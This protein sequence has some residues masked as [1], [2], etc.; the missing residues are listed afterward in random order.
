MNKVIHP[1][2]YVWDLM[3]FPLYWNIP[4]AVNIWKCCPTIRTY[5]V[6]NKLG[7]MNL[8]MAR[9]EGKNSWWEYIFKKEQ[10][11]LLNMVNDF[12]GFFYLS[13]YIKLGRNSISDSH[14][15]YFCN[16]YAILVVMQWSGANYYWP[17]EN[18]TEQRII[19]FFFV[20]SILQLRV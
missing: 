12:H 19:L 6:Y 15:H 2:C 3:L 13:I 17:V 18:Y 16:R 11:S 7:V 10:K 20:S 5:I 9:G 4:F 14:Q 8:M 1:F